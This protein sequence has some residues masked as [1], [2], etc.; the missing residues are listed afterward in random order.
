[1]L[2]SIIAIIYTITFAYLAWYMYDN[3][4]Q[5]GFMFANQVAAIAFL[6]AS[7]LAIKS[8]RGAEVPEIPKSV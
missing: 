6:A 7:Y 2:N 1:M 5:G 3:T 4:I 8:W